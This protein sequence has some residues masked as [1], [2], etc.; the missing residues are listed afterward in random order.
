M[1]N[2]VTMSIGWRKI[3]EGREEKRKGMKE[4]RE[5]GK[6]GKKKKKGRM[7]VNII[8]NGTFIFLQRWQLIVFPLHS[9][10][11]YTMHK[12]T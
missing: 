3:R 6:E 10:V 2:E 5:R 7:S 9:H 4:K 8:E 11:Q 12:S 1:S